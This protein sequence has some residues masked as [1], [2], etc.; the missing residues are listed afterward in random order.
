MAN[1]GYTY[2]ANAVPSS[3]YTPMPAGEYTLE[4]VKSE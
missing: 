3:G 2:N 4:L 1:I